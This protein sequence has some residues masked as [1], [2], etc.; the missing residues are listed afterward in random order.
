MA[1][2]PADDYGTLTTD[3]IV[4]AIGFRRKKG[5]GISSAEVPPAL[6]ESWVDEGVVA[7]MPPNDLPRT[8]ERAVTNRR[9]AKAKK[10][11]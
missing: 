6:W 3:V 9:A 5:S 4:Q 1:T 11:L 8:K 10:V 2:K 7:L